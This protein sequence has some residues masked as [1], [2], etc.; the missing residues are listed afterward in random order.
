MRTRRS[1]GV[2][3]WVGPDQQLHGEPGEEWDL[4]LRGLSAT[5]FY[6]K[7][8]ASEGRPFPWIVVTSGW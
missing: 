4:V 2:A 7:G 5:P 3:G 8:M 6:L 1:L